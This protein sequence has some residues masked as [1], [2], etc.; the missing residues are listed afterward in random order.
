MNKRFAYFEDVIIFFITIF[1]PYF[2]IALIAAK[3]SSDI[4]KFFAFDVPFANEAKSTH[5]MLKLLS[6]GTVIIFLKFYDFHLQV[7]F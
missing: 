5:L 1:M 2:L 3:T 4:N 7:E 6:P